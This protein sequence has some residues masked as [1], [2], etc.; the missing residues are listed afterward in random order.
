[1]YLRNEEIVNKQSNDLIR[2]A[3]KQRFQLSSA[4][5]ENVFSSPKWNF[6]K[7][8]VKWKWPVVIKEM[9]ITLIKIN[10]SQRASLAHCPREQRKFIHILIVTA[11]IQ[12]AMFLFI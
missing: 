11:F 5:Y 6:H 9:R 3:H 10:Q 4:N 2:T 7:T 12:F 1:M 8:V